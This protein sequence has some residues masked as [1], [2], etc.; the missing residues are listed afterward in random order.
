MNVLIIADELF[1]TRER[2]LL[3]RLEVGLADEGHG[4]AHAVPKS[5][6]EKTAGSSAELSGVFSKV[7]SYVPSSLSFTRRFV[8]RQMI[9]SLANLPGDF[10]RIDVVHVFGGASW[11]LA[12]DVASALDAPLVVEVWRRGLSV[13]ARELWSVSRG[14]A[15][16]STLFLASDAQIE[17]ELMTSADGASRGQ[18]AVP[19]PVRCVP[20][21]VLSPVHERLPVAGLGRDRPANIMIIGSGRHGGSAASPVWS[22]VLGACADLVANGFDLM[23]YADDLSAGRAR[24][25][26]VV[27]SLNLLSRLS[28]VDELEGRRDLMLHGDVLLLPEATDEARSIVLEA[29]AA[30]MLVIS[31]TGPAAPLLEDRRSALLVAPLDRSGWAAALETLF[32]RH[33]VAVGLADAAHLYVQ[34]HR[35]ASDYVR[36]VV[37]AYEH[38]AGRS[39]RI[40]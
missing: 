11:A 17:R 21:G 36:G 24:I 14:G 19:L 37:G 25:W 39:L 35:K 10:E 29:M 1:A 2:S 9:E 26:P 28:L 20:W 16:S 12:A 38:A 23:L 22:A 27:R 4:V 33:A 15:A 7:I 30:G 18:P 6:I 40:G 31:A 8:V 34:V 3:T 32:T 5:V 13:R